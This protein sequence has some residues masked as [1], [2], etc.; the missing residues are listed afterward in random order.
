METPDVAAKL[1]LLPESPGVYLMKDASGLIIYVG[2]AKSLKKRV[3]S[4]FRKNDHDMKTRALVRHIEDLEF[5]VTDT[6]MEA[7]LLENSLIK[8]HKPKYNIR[9]KDDKRYPYIAVT[10]SEEYPRI[11]YTRTLRRNGDRYF[12]PYT[13]SL[14][15][16]NTAQLITDIFKLR[17]CSKKIPLPKG[18][19]PCLNYQMKRC[20]G[21]CTGLV[22]REEYLASVNDALMFLEGNVAPV[23][24]GLQKKMEAHAA[25]FEYEKAAAA[26]DMIFHIQAIS[27]KQKVE[28]P[29]GQ[30]TDFVG[31]AIRGD[32]AI[33]VLFE[34]RGGILLGRKVR[35]FQNAQYSS[36]PEIMRAFLL[37]YYER[38]EPPARIVTQEKIEEAEL[39]AEHLCAASKKKVRLASA[40][41]REEHA[42]EG[43]IMRNIDLLFTERASQVDPSAALEELQKVLALEEY[44]EMIVCFDIS[45]TQGTNSVASMSCV[46]DGIPDTTNYRRFKIRG[47]DQANDPAMIHEAV[48]RYLQGGLNGEHAMPDLVVIDGGPTQLTRAKEAAAALGAEMPIIS[49]AKRNEELFTDPAKEPIVLPRTSEALK[50]IQRLRDEAHRFGVTYHR[51]LRGKEMVHSALDDIEGIGP[52][53]RTA[54]MQHFG[55]LENIRAATEENIASVD[56]I[57]ASDAKRIAAA[58]KTEEGRTTDENKF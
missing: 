43:M 41:S 39:V 5:I 24:A 16:K 18:E 54:L 58:L 9:L 32:E 34:F 38:S 21:V 17:L 7:L 20:T 19:R 25:A 28:I 27:E 11:L 50:L 31:A 35:L 56:G 8:K 47:Y 49:I 37:E 22:T 15:A 42:V 53:K 33:V 14:A 45:N 3:M 55:T 29:Q 44:P 10:T 48:A 2:K 6:E 23:L 1:K 46:T 40:R 13:D 36:V 26:R 52:A 30:D 4:Y 12:G 51:Q 57:S